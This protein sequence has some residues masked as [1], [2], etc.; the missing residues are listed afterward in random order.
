[1]KRRFSK[2]LNVLLSAA[3][4]LSIFSFAGAAG[5]GADNAPTTFFSSNS[6][7]EIVTVFVPTFREVTVTEVV[8]ST[9]TRTKTY[10]TTE[11][12]NGLFD[13]ENRTWWIVTVII[14][15]LVIGVL[16]VI[17]IVKK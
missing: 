1:M 9:I 17:L 2:I 15:G 12:S 3:L 5:V 11:V 7:I 4:V 10:T 8:T 13:F 6:E 16:L 14:A